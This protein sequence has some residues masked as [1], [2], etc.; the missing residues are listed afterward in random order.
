MSDN[1]NGLKINRKA[2]WLFVATMLCSLI[3]SPVWA[4]SGTSEYPDRRPKELTAAEVE[5]GKQA[6]LGA[7][8]NAADAGTANLPEF[9][10][11]ATE[12]SQGRVKINGRWERTQDVTG[13]DYN[14]AKAAKA[15]SV[16]AEGNMNDL[17]AL[18]DEEDAEIRAEGKT[19]ARSQ[20]YDSAYQSSDAYD[21]GKVEV[22][23]T[24][25]SNAVTGVQDGREGKVLGQTF[26]QCET[27]TTVIPGTR[28]STI[29]DEFVCE[30][31]VRPGDANGN[32][33]TRTR[34]YT[35]N[36]GPSVTGEKQAELFVNE[37]QN[38]LMC[39]K[40]TR[41][42]HYRD[43]LNGTK[44]A[45]L[46]FT[47]E[48]GGEVCK[49]ELVASP[50][51]KQVDNSL[52]SE[53]NVDAQSG[54]NLCKRT[55]VPSQHTQVN[56]DS[57]AG[58]LAINTDMPGEA[59]RSWVWAAMTTAAQT[60]SQDAIL[61]IDTQSG[62]NLCKRTLWP[63]S[64]STT[65]TN[66]KTSNLLINQDMPSTSCTKTVWPT[67]TQ[68][69]T[70]GTKH[71][72]LSINNE[73]P[74]QACQRWRNV[75]QAP[76]GIQT[77]QENSWFSGNAGPAW[78]EDRPM[79]HLIPAGVTLSSFTASI[80]H[81]VPGY[82]GDC[83]AVWVDRW[84][85]AANGYV[86]RFGF[87]AIP[88]NEPQHPGVC[89]RG[90]NGAP[91]IIQWQ[92]NS[93]GPKTFTI[94]ESGNCNDP[95]TP[96]CP[97]QWQCQVNAPTTINGIAVSAADVSGLALLYPGSS[98]I[99]VNATL[100][101]VCGGTGSVNNSISI[102]ADL[103]SGTTS[104]SG[105]GFFVENHQSGVNVVL[106]QTPSAANGWVAIFRV[107]RTNWGNVSAPNIIMQWNASSGGV[108]SGVQV[109]G[110]CGDS[111]T[112][113]CP[114][115]WSCT[116]YAPTVING[117]TVDAAMAASHAP[118]FPGASSS[119]A[120][121][122]LNRT[123]P[124]SHTSRTTISIAGDLPAGTTSI[125]DFSFT[126]NNPQTGV[127]ITPVQTPS[128][129]NG[130]NAV[131]DVTRANFAY[132]PSMPNITMT[133][134]S[135]IPV[136]N[137]TV[138]DSG[139][140]SASGTANCPATWTCQTHA[141]T[142][143]NGI[144]VTT[145]MTAS[146]APLFPGAASTCA[147][148][149]LDRVCSGTAS[150]SLN[151]SIA[152]NIPAGVTAITGFNQIVLNAQA[153]V[154]VVTTQVPSAANNWIA[155][156][157]VDRT[158]YATAHQQPEVRMTWNMQV[159]A[160]AITKQSSGNTTD[161]GTQACPTVWTCR[162][163]APTTINGIAVSAAQAAT[164]APLYPGAANS[165]TLGTLDRV[166]GG[167]ATGST[168]LSI[169][170]KIPSGITSIYGFAFTVSNPQN[171]VTVSLT[172]APSA[173]NGWNA[174]FS[175]TR[176]D[177]TYT[178]VAP[179]VNMTWNYDTTITNVTV[180]DTGNCAASGSPSCPATWS[181]STNAPT[182]LNGIPV[183][184]AL[185]ATKAPLF[186]GAP[187]TCAVG[188]LDKVCSGTASIQTSISIA[189]AL[190]PGT[191]AISGFTHTVTN[192]QAGV[193]VTLLQTPAAA[194]SW[195][196]IFRVDRSNWSTMPVK[197]K[198]HM[199]WSSTV[200]DVAATV[201][202][203]GNCNDPGTTA[204]PTR[205]TCTASA[206]TQSN[207]L[208]ISAALAQTF[209]PLYPGA[210]NSACTKA[211][212]NKVCDGSSGMD[213]TISIAELVTPDA[214][215]I[216]DFQWTINNPNP[217]L[218][219]DLLQAP[220]LSNNWVARFRVVRQYT[221]G[222]PTPAAPSITLTWNM[223]S[224]QKVRVRVES[225][226]NCGAGGG[227]GTGGMAFF[228][229]EHDVG[230]PQRVA[231]KTT[232]RTYRSDLSLADAALNLLIPA[233]HAQETET[234][235]VGDPPSDV[236]P[237]CPL[238]WVCTQ[239]M[240]GS[241]DGIALTVAD[242]QQRGELYPGEN[243]TCLIA[244]QRSICSGSGQNQ[245]VVSIK[246]QVPDYVD[247]ISNFGWSV[248]SGGTGVGVTLVQTPEK[249]N[250][251]TA[252]FET[253][254]TDWSVTPTKP[255]VRLTWGMNG[256]PVPDWSIDDEGNCSTEGD[257]FCTAKWRC[258]K[259]AP[260][261]P[262]PSTPVT[263]QNQYAIAPAYED[264]VINISGHLGGAT[265]INGFSW[266]TVAA[267]NTTV[268]MLSGPSASNGWQATFR[269]T[270]A[271]GTGGGGGGPRPGE[272]E[273]P[274][275]QANVD[276]KAAPEA[277][278]MLAVAGETALNALIPV[279]GAAVCVTCDD[280]GGGGGGTY[281]Y[282]A[283]ISVTFTP[284]DAPADVPPPYAEDMVGQPPLFE[285]DG[286]KCLKAEK[287]YDCGNIWVGEECYIDSDGVERC[288]N[289]PPSD[290]PPN[291]C[292][293]YEEN[294]QCSLIREECTAGGMNSAGYC[295]IK[296]K[297][298]S[299]S[300][301]I[302]VD[303]P[304]IH[305][306]TICKGSEAGFTPI[307]MDGTC[308]DE[309]T[310]D[311]QGTDLAKPAAKM[312]VVQHQMK[313]Y[314]VVGGGSPPGGGGGGPGDPNVPVNPRNLSSVG[315]VLVDALVG[316]A[317]AQ[318]TPTLPDPFAPPGGEDP[319]DTPLDPSQFGG[320]TA[321]QAGWNMNNLRFFAGQ[322]RDC[323]K[324]LGGLLNC[325]KKRPPQDQAPTFW[326][327]LEKH[328]R[329]T[330]NAQGQEDQ[331]DED[332][333]GAW[334]S[335]LSGGL[336][337]HE[338]L[339]KKLTSNMES[340]LGGGTTGGGSDTD[341][342]IGNAYQQFKTHEVTVEKPKLAWYCDNDEFELAVGQQIGTCSHLGSYCQTKVLGMCVI[343]KDRYCCFNSPVTRIL[344]ENLRDRGVAT[345][346]TA[347]HPKCDGITF[348]QM[349]QIN[350][351]QVDDSEIIG[352]MD[353]GKFLPGMAQMA[354]MDLSEME[355][356]LD[357]M[358]SAL[359]DSTR[360]TPTDRNSMRL[361]Q[362]DTGGSYQSIEQSQQG[363]K[364]EAMTDPASEHTST[365]AFATPTTELK[366]APGRGMQIPIQRDGVDGG[367]IVLRLLTGSGS[368]AVVGRDYS[369][370]RNPISSFSTTTTANFRISAPEAAVEGGVIYLTLQASRTSGTGATSVKGVDTIK[371]TITKD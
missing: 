112:S 137:V 175:V 5:Q 147:V 265:T 287:Y 98:S 355:K 85:S 161:P 9:E 238:Q 174:V 12:N 243:Y 130:W 248:V 105:F 215:E 358:N 4:Q 367:E 106:L 236:P 284:G 365:V 157:R 366:L 148:G 242:L 25:W 274:I 83:N 345:M 99:C 13:G 15:N 53:L 156:F 140:C 81:D 114:S 332:Q 266:A 292:K 59:G 103:P 3:F 42:E 74:V 270:A 121:A 259:E 325:C 253:S 202:D 333:E 166:C 314:Q 71:A 159:P 338:D 46:P 96:N 14:E 239:P 288:V 78:Y 205:W 41:A 229:G 167:S 73:T 254:R 182:T 331:E 63:T 75:T 305:K 340:L 163:S 301:T 317:F 127:T 38:G 363:Y 55:L 37:Q 144:A 125:S 312:M 43:T 250:A 109:S 135:N 94:Q 300:K 171:G 222:A 348:E 195:V 189:G 30:E 245:T 92:Y 113:V 192:P 34:G 308:Y 272:P 142:T 70:P 97:T 185:A 225:S 27:T 360:M 211:S 176:T 134:T 295:Y 269:I 61:P 118:L 261:R 204:C 224:E 326:S 52:D 193:T 313:D 362:M 36:P 324:A 297:L 241:A 26:A 141:P 179:D 155:T 226:G 48:T 210:T 221:P 260:P 369:I 91:F 129:A 319:D 219:V 343:K 54:G 232:G 346:G 368:T 357:G 217:A 72:T 173:A 131:F 304:E 50:T 90:G 170:A 6:G 65:Q 116:G 152:A 128:A 62:G 24:D 347:K 150:T 330:S 352:R 126:V 371:I 206:P 275:E 341:D 328:L 95:G 93:P 342:S 100:N 251:W 132:A 23:A 33:C 276:G 22:E 169:A 337:S 255:T 285:G 361:G 181:C 122:S 153:G 101:R 82:Y 88:M 237:T 249:G 87:Q 220:A 79:S 296:S 356:L 84:P 177:F 227:S 247:T 334:K 40:T 191:T 291:S 268:Q 315:D 143:I 233:V 187:N 283:T 199:E 160:V 223:L 278:T 194:N 323:M 294:P 180:A 258:I 186:P 263:I 69:N 349:R 56:A 119:C 327:F 298:Y 149:S 165:C 102:A 17:K 39:T 370:D 80:D 146:K 110:N 162:Q 158:S 280:G 353:Q 246:D 11:G 133:W 286:G 209:S 320:F 257:E 89:E 154:S 190:S 329:K 216:T 168:T 231:T 198:I 200:P 273:T 8:K 311:E 364:P 318:S 10:A 336:P 47:E 303:N 178:P 188:S 228:T 289:Q 64:G 321:P 267:R 111:G 104:I 16:K 35:E 207:G 256:A 20:A 240:P 213:S 29:K 277:T 212:L 115:Q 172:Q 262:T 234:P 271:S 309:T 2:S 107:D 57:M 359:G 51:T 60:G 351:D 281:Y 28:E 151:V 76:G 197:P 306:E 344:R 117:I 49:R 339:M 252:I 302:T 322:R 123:C 264:V 184:A 66:S 203:T 244:E 282:T 21:R 230:V 138:S 108:S 183:S 208:T 68:V 316:K 18:H 31:V 299:C 214:T 7:G 307:C 335:M 77:G 136:T 218:S 32:I 164:V 124:S 67:S 354:N 279:A 86:A 58:S 293:E 145:T 45:T 120:S 235:G 310:R 44:T 196:A 201:V 290:T 350:P 19:T 1:H 139:N